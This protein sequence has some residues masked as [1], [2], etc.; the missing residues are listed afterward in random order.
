M[1]TSGKRRPDHL[2]DD[3]RMMGSAFRHTTYGEKK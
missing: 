1:Y 3:D 2:A